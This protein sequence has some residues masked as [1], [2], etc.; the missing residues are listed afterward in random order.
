M[1][2]EA[3]GAVRFVVLGHKFSIQLAVAAVAGAV[4]HVVAVFVDVAIDA[5]HFGADAANVVVGQAELGQIMV[6]ID[7]SGRF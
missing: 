4:L 6:E 5:G 2:G 7:H 1:A 3:V